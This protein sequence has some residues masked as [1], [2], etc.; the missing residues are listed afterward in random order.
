MKVSVTLKCGSVETRD[1]PL[2]CNTLYSC[3]NMV[4]TEIFQAKN[5]EEEEKEKEDEEEAAKKKERRSS[6]SFFFWP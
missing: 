4:H 5:E 2:G 3:S 1:L 6:S